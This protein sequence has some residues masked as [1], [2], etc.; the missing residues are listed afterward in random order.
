MPLLSAFENNLHRTEVETININFLTFT[1]TTRQFT[2]YNLSY[3]E[4]RV[5]CFPNPTLTSKKQIHTPNLDMH[6]PPCLTSKPPPGHF[7]SKI[8]GIDFTPPKHA[9]NS[10]HLYFTHISLAW[11]L[12]DLIRNNPSVSSF[13][14]SMP[15]KCLKTFHSILS[16]L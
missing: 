9:V 4:H 5:A 13:H 3:I 6:S 14:S 1:C 16:L 12:W 11:N 8:S 7:P 15:T 10:F 2:I